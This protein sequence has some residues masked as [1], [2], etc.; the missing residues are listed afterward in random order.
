MWVMDLFVAEPGEF[1][2][3]KKSVSAVVGVNS[4]RCRSGQV[5]RLFA[6]AWGL[7]QGYSLE[8]KL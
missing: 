2:P 5:N 4:L 8:G 7:V 1:S 3:R 6:R